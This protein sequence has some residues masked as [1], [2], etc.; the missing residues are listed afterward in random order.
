MSA[1]FFSNNDPNLPSLNLNEAP[2]IKKGLPK[3]S[4]L[5]KMQIQGDDILFDIDGRS[6]TMND[7]ANELST[8]FIQS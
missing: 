5:S 2:K 4:S 3:L 8:L 6:L 1:N 7:V